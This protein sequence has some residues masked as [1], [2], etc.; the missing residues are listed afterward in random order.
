MYSCECKSYTC[1]LVYACLLCNV[2]SE[3]AELLSLNRFV[4]DHSCLKVLDVSGNEG[5]GNHGCVE[6]LHCCATAVDLR[7]NLAACNMN[8]P[9]PNELITALSNL[10]A[11]HRVEVIGNKI[12]QADHDHI[13]TYVL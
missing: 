9:L 12:S 6:L 11:K 4:A 8:S 3:T 2:H 1:T 5:L 10:L 7:L 13:Y